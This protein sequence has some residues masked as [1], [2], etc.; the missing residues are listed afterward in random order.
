MIGSNSVNP[1]WNQETRSRCKDSRV[2]TAKILKTKIKRITTKTYFYLLLVFR[3]LRWSKNCS[4]SVWNRS[5]CWNSALKHYHKT[6]EKSSIS[7]LQIYVFQF[8][9]FHNPTHP[10][11]AHLMHNCGV[12]LL[13]YQRILDYFSC[14]FQDGRRS[15][16]LLK[17]RNCSKHFRK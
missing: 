4:H 13:S 5:S 15:T 7:R 8:P 6:W 14:P 2:G 12:V 11:T 1:D 3:L 9:T 10:H 16:F 17:E